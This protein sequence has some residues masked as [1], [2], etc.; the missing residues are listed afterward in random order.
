MTGNTNT[1]TNK[2]NYYDGDDDGP[3]RKKQKI[4][5]DK[6]KLP[7]LIRRKIDKL[8][9]STFVT[10]DDNLNATA[11]IQGVCTAIHVLLCHV[12]LNINRES[13]DEVESAIRLFPRVLSMKWQQ[14]TDYNDDSLAGYYPI[15][16]QVVQNDNGKFRECRPHGVV[17][18]PLLIRLALEFRI[19]KDE[20]RGGLLINDINGNP[21]LQSLVMSSN[22]ND[23]KYNNN[24]HYTIADDTFLDTLI[25]L[26]EMEC[27]KKEDIWDNDL[28]NILCDSRNPS[29]FSFKRF[30]FLVECNPNPLTR[31]TK[32]HNYLPLHFA[33]NK[34]DIRIFRT[35]LKAGI[36]Y[37]P[38]KAQGITLLFRKDDRDETPFYDACKKYG[39]EETM[40]VI[41][42][43]FI[44]CGCGCYEY[45]TSNTVGALLFAAFDENVHLD[46]VYFLLRNDP[47]LAQK[48]LSIINSTSTNN[49]KYYNDGGSMKRQKM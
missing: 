49:D 48:L 13:I 31:G 29:Y 40:K 47:N 22:S 19:F 46:G 7:S 9:V 16:L 39:N 15:S 27:I 6:H 30:Q 12:R 8:I 3:Q 2:R 25:K 34:S 41:G 32:I 28:L 23:Q 20:F 43:T 5:Q 24:K 37:L 17:F 21:V 42:E 44:D 35:V 18:I 1:S 38:K 11:F 45:D 4:L 10:E 26:K 14:E 36:Q 33:A